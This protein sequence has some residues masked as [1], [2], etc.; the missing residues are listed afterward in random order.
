M[1]H[2]KLLTLFLLWFTG[3]R[4]KHSNHDTKD[5][6]EVTGKTIQN[7]F[8]ISKDTII[9]CKYG[10][11]LILSTDAG[12]NWTELKTDLL[13]DEVTI[14]D[15]GY[16]IGLDS[17]QGIHEQ[18]YSRLYLSKDFGKTWQIFKLDTKIF[19]PLHFISKPKEKVLVQTFDNKVYQLNGLNLKTDWTLIKSVK[20]TDKENNKSALPFAIDDYND[21][22]IKLFNARNTPIDTLAILD[23]CR[24]VNDMISTNKFVYIAGTGYKNSSDEETYAYFASYNKQNG[25]KQYV[26]PGH[27]AYLK[28]T[29]LERVYIMND[30]GLFIANQDTLKKLY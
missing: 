17:W 9:A 20:P 15:S 13:F 29:H 4:Q 6:S 28:K 3:C 23:K 11:G 26:I 2:L 24:Q 12:L 7:V 8:D 21:H 25:L 19:F 22:R 5:F 27:Y 30:V 16:L 14:S 1:R 10:Q 18:D